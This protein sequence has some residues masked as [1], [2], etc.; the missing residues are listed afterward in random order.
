MSAGK[1]VV[2]FGE[3]V[4]KSRAEFAPFW[5]PFGSPHRLGR[6]A[7]CHS[8]RRAREDAQTKAHLLA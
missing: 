6:L 7:V 4:P 1:L 2:L 8:L 5:L 3:I